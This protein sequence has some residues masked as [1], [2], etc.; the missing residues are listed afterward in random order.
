MRSGRLEPGQ[1]ILCAVPESG[2]CQM[3]YAR[4]TVV[5]G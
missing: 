2:R 5:E 3:G 4:M 1:T